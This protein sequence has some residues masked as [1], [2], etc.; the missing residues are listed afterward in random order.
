MDVGNTVAHPSCYACEHTHLPAAKPA[1]ICTKVWVWSVHLVEGKDAVQYSLPKFFFV[2]ESAPKVSSGPVDAPTMQKSHTDPELV[3]NQLRLIAIDSCAVSLFIHRRAVRN[4]DFPGL[5]QDER[6][7]R[8][9]LCS[10]IPL[11]TR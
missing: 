11:E 1:G 6:N 5:R 7:V 10:T 2:T 8:R 4:V 9:L 3:R